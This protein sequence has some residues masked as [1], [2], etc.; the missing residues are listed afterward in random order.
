MNYKKLKGQRKAEILLFNDFIFNYD[1]V[2]NGKE[3]WRCG[4]RACKAFI[5]L[6]DEKIDLINTHNHE[7]SKSKIDRIEFNNKIKNR[8]KN[9]TEKADTI[10]VRNTRD[11]ADDDL[12]DVTKLRSI[13]KMISRERSKEYGLSV[14]KFIDI[15]EQLR[16][17]HQKNQFLMYDSGYED[18]NRYVIF[19]SK[20]KEKYINQSD[21]W[22]IDGTFKSTPSDFYQL[23][24]IHIFILGKSFPAFYILL[25]NKKEISYMN[26]FS[27]I[28]ENSRVN[29]KILITDFEIAL[30]S[31]VKEQ[32]PNANHYFCLFHYSQ[33]IFR[34]L[35]T[36]GFRN[37]YKNDSVFSKLIKKIFNLPFLP[38]YRKTDAFENIEKL[39][40]ETG[41]QNIV[42]F[43]EYYKKT[44]FGIKDKD[45]NFK[46]S[47][48]SPVDW[49]CYER[50]LSCIPRTSNNVEGWNRSFNKT[51]VVNN[52]N[53]AVL[54]GAMQDQEELNRVEII[55]MITGGIEIRVNLKREESLRLLLQNHQFF[56][57]EEFF[58][59]IEKFF[60]WKFQ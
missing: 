48:F 59:A 28:K 18:E 14:M 10:I 50:V 6:K 12:F 43:L 40:L 20:F 58:N 7:H 16:I 38:T 23:V 36:L 44:F 3:R 39:L 15:P 25:R 47:L 26:A 55:K 2:V 13:K 56:N 35:S 31:S 49:S 29:P 5:F 21:I 51:C 24:T 45:N 19:S 52:P 34:R 53:I 22:L 4:S 8:A 32:F 17:D 60:K 41:E 27:Y 33:A 42:D 1:K 37:K 11:M 30:F 57:D 9:T 46:K 54:I